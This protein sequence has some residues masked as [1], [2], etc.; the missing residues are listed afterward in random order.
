ME[1]LR[2]SLLSFSPQN[3]EYFNTIESAAF[4]VCLDQGSPET[5]EEQARHCRLGDGSNRWHDK[6]VQ[7]VVAAN[8]NSGVIFEHSYIDGTLPLPLHSR[9]ADAIN[10]YRPDIHKSNGH[11]VK[12]PRELRLAT[13]AKADERIPVLKDK[14]AA[15]SSARDFLF[16]P[17]PELGAKLV[18]AHNLPLKGT[19]DATLQLAMHIYYGTLPVNWQPVALTQFHEGRHDLVQLNSPAVMAFCKSAADDSIPVSSRR[20]LMLAAAT[21]INARIRDAR[22]GHGYYRLFHVIDKQCPA[23]SPKPAIY[24]HPLQRRLDDFTNISYI[25]DEKFENV[26]VSLDPEALRM[27]Y[28][29]GQDGYV[30]SFSFSPINHLILC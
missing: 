10:E 24:D 23:D 28:T 3:A 17:V 1:Q 25:N 22:D 30:F 2:D 19:F 7:F 13:D 4:I 27:K 6:G 14:W 9:I 26:L 29:I 15:F 5:L 21:D 18:T 12:V 20:A 8:G 16:H 11:V